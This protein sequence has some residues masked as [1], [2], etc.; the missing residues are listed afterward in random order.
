MSSWVVD[1]KTGDYLSTN[2]SP[3]NSEDLRI[4]AFY[5][6]K[7]HRQGWMYAPDPNYGSDYYL[8]RKRHKPSDA[9][10][11]ETIGSKAL[12]PIIDDG[13]A[14]DISMTTTL[15]TRNGTTLETLITD[16]SGVEQEL[17]L[18]PISVG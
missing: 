12:Q 17:N 18:N 16:A 11:I 3:T 13:R 1:P 2:G 15:T 14:T 5:R 4:P 8:L 9:R 10:S 6:L 7:I